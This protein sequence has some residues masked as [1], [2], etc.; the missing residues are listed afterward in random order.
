MAK[1]QAEEAAEAEAT[2]EKAVITAKARRE[3]AETSLRQMETSLR[4]MLCVCAAAS[5]FIGVSAARP[6]AIVWWPNTYMPTLTCALLVLVPGLFGSWF[7]LRAPWISGA[8]ITCDTLKIDASVATRRAEA[9]PQSWCAYARPWL[10]SF[11][12]FGLFNR[13]LIAQAT[14]VVGAVGPC[15]ITDGGACA[16]SPNYPK[17]YGINGSCTIF[18]VPAAPLDVLWFDV[19][20]A[21]PCSDYLTV[22]GTQFCGNSGPAGMVAVDGIIAWNSDSSAGENHRWKV[23]WAALSPRA[24]FVDHREAAFMEL[25][26]D[27]DGTVTDEELGFDV[28]HRPLPSP[29]PPSPPLVDYRKAAFM[30]LDTDGDGTVTDKELG[31]PVNPGHPRRRMF[32]PVLVAIGE[33]VVGPAAAAALSEAVLASI[34]AAAAGTIGAAA[35][36]A[37][38]K[39]NGDFYASW[40]ILKRDYQVFWE[41]DQCQNSCGRTTCEVASVGRSCSDLSNFGCDC[42]GCCDLEVKDTAVVEYDGNAFYCDCTWSR[43]FPCPGSRS[44]SPDFISHANND[45]SPCFQFCCEGRTHDTGGTE[46]HGALV[47]E[48]AAETNKQVAD[49]ATLV[50]ALVVLPPVGLFLFLMTRRRTA[51]IGEMV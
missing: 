24:G 41:Q 17:S 20:Q 18:N 51:D 19:S 43:Y 3:D 31:F 10:I 15:E 35:V 28:F 38:Y 7:Y 39:T 45:G 49:S 37:L 34:G 27:G 25:D 23:C 30:E 33:V 21:T 36:A 44:D 9:A 40:G 8:A 32:V 2:A 48:M 1:G 13:L 16:T 42:H 26:A 29:S 5:S 6:L 47:K 46:Q 4:Q 11:L 14:K 50:A 12:L 22:N